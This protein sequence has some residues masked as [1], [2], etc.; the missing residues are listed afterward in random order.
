VKTVMTL[1]W[2]RHIRV[3]VIPIVEDFTVN[4]TYR[5]AIKPLFLYF[6]IFKLFRRDNDNEE[7]AMSKIFNTR[8]N[9]HLVKNLVVQNLIITSQQFD[10]IRPLIIFGTYMFFVEKS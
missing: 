10:V 2:Y 7:D 8:A 4:V 6:G 5:T 3:R 1:T 9:L